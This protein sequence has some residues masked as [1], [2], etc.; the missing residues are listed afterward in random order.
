MVDGRD[1]AAWEEP[2]APGAALAFCES[3][4]NPA[5]E[6]IDLAEVGG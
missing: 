1:L 3:P 2:L 6:I 5:M 4:S